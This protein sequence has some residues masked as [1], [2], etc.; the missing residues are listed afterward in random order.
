[1]NEMLK[2]YKHRVSDKD[3]SAINVAS[4]NQGITNNKTHRAWYFK[5]AQVASSN[6]D[7]NIPV[8]IFMNM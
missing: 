5:I 6:G 1:M 2:N 4:S 3:L 8:C 7:N